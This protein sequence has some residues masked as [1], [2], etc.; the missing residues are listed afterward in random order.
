[1]T[2]MIASIV[3]IEMIMFTVVLTVAFLVRG[4]VRSGA[5]VQEFRYPQD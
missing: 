1:M 4:I 2:S 3:V 5:A